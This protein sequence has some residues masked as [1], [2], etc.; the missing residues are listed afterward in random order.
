[1]AIVNVT[2]DSFSDGGETPDEDGAVARGLALTEAGA[3]LVDVGGESTRP[4]ADPVAAAE[5]MRRVLPVV[6]RLVAAGVTVSVDTRQADIMATVIACGAAIIND[7]TALTGD[8]RAL[9]TVAA[10]DVSIVLMHMQGE[11]RSM[12]VA[13]RYDDV[14]AEVG[15]WLASRV[16]VCV[17]AGIERERIAVDPGIGFGKTLDHNLRLLACLDQLRPPGCALVVGASRKSFLTRLGS[18]VPPRQRVAGSLAAALWAAT[19]GVD[20]VR[21]HDVSETCRALAAWRAIAGAATESS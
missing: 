12:Q 20:I 14:V 16:D 11:P 3:D 4:G 1:M 17:A 10:S 7:V 13:P 6:R 8:E 15:A 5:E 18:D 9:A 19:K 21:V 2:P